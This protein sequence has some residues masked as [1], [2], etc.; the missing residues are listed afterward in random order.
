M[1]IIV[2]QQNDM[3]IFKYFRKPF[4]FQLKLKMVIQKYKITIHL[5]IETYSV[6]VTIRVDF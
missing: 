5:N 6:C 1:E 2:V 4:T 3:N